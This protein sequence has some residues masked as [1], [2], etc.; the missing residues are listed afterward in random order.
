MGSFSENLASYLSPK[1]RLSRSAYLRISMR[2]V[3]VTLALIVIAIFLA[4][5]GLRYGAF[6]TAAA[7]GL[8]LISS[9]GTFVRRLHDRGLS[10]W[11]AA[12]SLGI[13][14]F[15]RALEDFK[16]TPLYVIVFV[17]ALI[18]LWL[19]LET[20]FRRGQTGSNRYGPDPYGSDEMIEFP[21]PL[22]EN[23]F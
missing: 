16:S 7:C 5:H 15:S 23:S 21:R 20:V 18:Q 9:L 11:F 10:G 13:P 19:L 6:V 17:L 12:V 14:V 1:G 4:A 3:F 22:R 2:L 8:V